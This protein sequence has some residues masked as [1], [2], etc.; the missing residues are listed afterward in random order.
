MKRNARER[1]HE[2]LVASSLDIDTGGILRMIRPVFRRIARRAVRIDEVFSVWTNCMSSI[3]NARAGE[4]VHDDDDDDDDDDDEDDDEDE[5]EGTSR[6]R[7][8][9][10][11]D[12][13]PS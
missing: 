2:F 11:L 13:A 6:R 4:N 12:C 10:P 8:P 9:Y 5:E 7:R 1:E 3:Q